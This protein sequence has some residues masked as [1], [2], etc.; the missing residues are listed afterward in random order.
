MAARS[1]QHQSSDPD[2][3]P[4]RLFLLASRS[5]LHWRGW[6]SRANLIMALFASSIGETLSDSGDQLLL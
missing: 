6:L 1:D 4:L 2:S 3:K 5:S